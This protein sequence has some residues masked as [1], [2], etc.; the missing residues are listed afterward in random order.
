V[1]LIPEVENLIIKELNVSPAGATD[2]HKHIPA[3]LLINSMKLEGT[4][5][6]QMSLQE[7]HNLWRKQAL[8]ALRAEVD[9]GK[10]QSSAQR[11]RRFTATASK[12][13]PADINWQKACVDRFRE[14]I[15]FPIPDCVPVPRPF[16]TKLHEL[17]EGNAD[18]MQTEESKERV[19]LVTH[20]VEQVS[21]VH[22]EALAA[23]GNSNLNAEVVHE[24]EAEAEEEAEEEAEQE[25]QKISAFTR[26]DEQHNPWAVK[27]LGAKPSFK[28]LN[29]AFYKFSDFK[30]NAAFFVSARTSLE[31]TP[32]AAA[33]AGKSTTTGLSF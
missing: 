1:Y 4:Q 25:E 31:L 10:E 8:A 7:L 15:G 3:W 14:H 11:L 13:P 32:H 2:M 16:S 22:S 9:E 17:I 27:L 5:F 6:L 23:A 30:V 19:K 26:D 33:G 21:R 28:D 12:K 20:K 29:Q 24:N 18:F